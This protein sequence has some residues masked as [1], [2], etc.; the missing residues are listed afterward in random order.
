MAKKAQ[1]ARAHHWPA[2]MRDSNSVEGVISTLSG[3]L[4]GACGTLC[5]LPIISVDQRTHLTAPTPTLTSGTQVREKLLL[6]SLAAVNFTHIVDFMI[7]MPLGPE[8]TRIFQITDA[9][10]GILVSAY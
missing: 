4:R 10:F 2:L 9:Q 7:M 1:A 5:G 8:L 6:W 3:L